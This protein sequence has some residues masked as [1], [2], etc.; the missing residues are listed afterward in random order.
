MWLEEEDFLKTDVRNNYFYY[1]FISDGKVLSSVI[2]TYPKQFDF[3]DPELSCEICNGEV[4]IHA[5]S[6][7][8]SVELYSPDSDPIFEDN[9]L[10]L[11]SEQRESKFLRAHPRKS[12]YVPFMI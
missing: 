11:I 12:N 10:I 6:Y 1:E 3:V 7:A 8:K 2:F 5:K 4:F 9:F